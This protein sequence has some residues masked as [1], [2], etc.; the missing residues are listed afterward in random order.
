MQLSFIGAKEDGLNL[1]L[2][3]ACRIKCLYIINMFND[4]SPY[5]LIELH[6]L[7]ASHLIRTKVMTGISMRLSTRQKKHRVN[8]ILQEKRNRIHSSDSLA[9]TQFSKQR[10][11]GDLHSADCFSYCAY[12]RNERKTPSVKQNQTKRTRSNVVSGTICCFVC[13][14]FSVSASSTSTEGVRCHRTADQEIDVHSFCRIIRAAGNLN[15]IYASLE[16]ISQI[17]HHIITYYHNDCTA[18]AGD[19]VPFSA[20]L[21]PRFSATVPCQAHIGNM[22][23]KRSECRSPNALAASRAHAGLNHVVRSKRGKKCHRKKT[24]RFF[25]QTFK[26]FVCPFLRINSFYK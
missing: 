7:C 16:T 6:T 22:Y 14:R 15:G 11:R 13:R 18:S 2:L 21:M 5:I 17:H 10:E 23:S 12:N 8:N 25:I 4:L 26:L 3:T 9:V 19:D 24:I 20:L 1:V